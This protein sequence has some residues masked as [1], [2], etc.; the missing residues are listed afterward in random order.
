MSKNN[1]WNTHFSN[2]E[3]DKSA[4]E[5]QHINQ[6]LSTIAAQEIPAEKRGRVSE[7]IEFALLHE[8]IEFAIRANLEHLFD[9]L[10]KLRDGR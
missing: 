2:G 4:K 7:Y 5:V 9:Q 8:V 3:Y 6:V 10:H 1:F